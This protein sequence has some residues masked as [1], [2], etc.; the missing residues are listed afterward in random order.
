LAIGILRSR[1]FASR[2]A[3]GSKDA[4]T[5][6]LNALML[7]TTIID[8][9]FGAL[10]G[11]PWFIPSDTGI[12]FIKKEAEADPFVSLIYLPNSTLVGPSHRLE[13]GPESH[14]AAIDEASYSEGAVTDEE[15]IELFKEN[16][17]GVAGPT[18]KITQVRPLK[19]SG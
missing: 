9:Q 12:C 14:F 5:P 18:I 3:L 10:P 17:R 19:D 16:Q 15:F 6:A 2:T 4:R 7:M 1:S 11:L 8:H 13:D